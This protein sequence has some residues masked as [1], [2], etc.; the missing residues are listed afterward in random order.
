MKKLFLL[1]IILSTLYG[2][3]AAENR[4]GLLVDNCRNII[5]KPLIISFNPKSCDINFD[6][7]KSA[8]EIKSLKSFY[9]YEPA[10]IL[11]PD[12]IRISFLSHI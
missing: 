4:L 11:D 7:K 6:L 12:N 8:V 5:D 3:C 10:L 1:A 2:I 9:N